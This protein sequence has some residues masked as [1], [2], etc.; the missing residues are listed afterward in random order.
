MTETPS[1][2]AQGKERE[3]PSSAVVGCCRLRVSPPCDPPPC[4]YRRSPH[5]AGRFNHPTSLRRVAIFPPL[6]SPHPRAAGSRVVGFPSPASP[7]ADVLLFSPVIPF[8]S[9]PFPPPLHVVFP[10]GSPR[11]PRSPLSWRATTRGEVLA[12]PTSTRGVPTTLSRIYYAQFS[13]SRDVFIF[14]STPERCVHRVFRDSPSFFSSLSFSLSLSSSLSSPLRRFPCA[15]PVSPLYCSSVFLSLAP[16]SLDPP[17]R[18]GPLS[19][20]YQPERVFFVFFFRETPPRRSFRSRI[21]IA[22]LSVPRLVVA[23][24]HAARLRCVYTRVAVHEPPADVWISF[25]SSLGR[26][27]GLKC[28][29]PVTIT[30]KLKK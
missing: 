12:S 17:L 6:T 1:Y 2:S 23:A 27:R 14:G 3:G 7:L 10:R 18:R 19:P 16:V 26:T 15:V 24:T 20:P 25:L 8:R 9:A 29:S 22:V 11:Q 21:I 28:V 5:Q 4:L 30:Y 13:C